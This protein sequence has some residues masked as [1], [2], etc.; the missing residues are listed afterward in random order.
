MQPLLC[1]VVGIYLKIKLLADI[2]F[3]L[4]LKTPGII[5]TLLF[6]EIGCL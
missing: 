2:R 3:N 4:S 5:V 1:E 6:V